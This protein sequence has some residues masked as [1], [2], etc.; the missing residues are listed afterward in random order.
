MYVTFLLP[1]D[2]KG[3]RAFCGFLVDHRGAGQNI[4]YFSAYSKKYKLSNFFLGILYS[5]RVWLYQKT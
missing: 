5:V 1:P 3:L 2:V 4:L